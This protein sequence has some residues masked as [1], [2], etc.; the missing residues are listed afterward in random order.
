MTRDPG[1]VEAVLEG[2][3]SGSGSVTQYPESPKLDGRL[4]AIL[5]YAVKLTR[6][7]GEVEEADLAPLREAGLDDRAIL[8]VVQV[9]AYYNYVNRMADGLGVELEEGWP[10]AE[11]RLR[12]PPGSS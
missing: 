1:L 5:H 7:P 4:R 8:D 6:T 10:D 3:E 2:P 12:A 9:T 11:R